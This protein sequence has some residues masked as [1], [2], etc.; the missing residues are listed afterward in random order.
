MIFK[1]RPRVIVRK[2][3]QTGKSIKS[4]DKKRKALGIGY[5]M[6]KSGKIYYEARKNRS[7]KSRRRKI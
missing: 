4:L 6:S 5:R 2:K 3:K 1:K 7:D